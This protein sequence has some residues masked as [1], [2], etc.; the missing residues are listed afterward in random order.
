MTDSAEREGTCL[1]VA[2]MCDVAGC[3]FGIRATVER[4]N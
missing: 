1:P 4:V 2:A 3:E